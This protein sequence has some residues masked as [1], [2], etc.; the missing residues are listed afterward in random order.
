MFISKINH[1]CPLTEIQDCTCPLVTARQPGGAAERRDWGEVS[2]GYDTS[3][4]DPR[5]GRPEAHERELART[6]QGSPVYS[7]VVMAEVNQ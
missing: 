3:S 6:G 7:F 4:L 1:I 2:R 5:S